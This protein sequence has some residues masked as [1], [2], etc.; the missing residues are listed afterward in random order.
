MFLPLPPALLSPPP[1]KHAFPQALPPHAFLGLASV[2][3][4][5]A[6]SSPLTIEEVTRIGTPCSAVLLNPFGNVPLW[7]E[8][9]VAITWRSRGDHVAIT[10]GGA[11]GD[12]VE[13]HVAITLFPRAAHLPSS[14]SNPP[15]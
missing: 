4:A 6:K 10:L 15:A 8:V 2:L 1:F 13:V 11:R 9:H 7:A 12:H 5:F 3:E 14:G